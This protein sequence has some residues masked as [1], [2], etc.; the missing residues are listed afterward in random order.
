MAREDSGR[1]RLWS[2]RACVIRDRDG[3]RA[4]DARASQLPFLRQAVELLRVLPGAADRLEFS[5]HE[6]SYFAREA[7]LARQFDCRSDFQRLA[8]AESGARPFDAGGRD[9]DGL[10]VRSRTKYPAARF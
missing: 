4:A 2:V 5:T 7:P 8:L 1:H 6:S 9:R 3:S 10:D